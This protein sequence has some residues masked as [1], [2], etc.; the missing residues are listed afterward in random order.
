MR[1]YLAVLKDSFRE[2]L[3]SRVLWI[4]MILTTVVLLAAAPL[5]L[6]EEKSSRLR[7]SSVRN[8]PALVAKIDQELR[9]GGPSPGSQIAVRLSNELKAALDESLK[10][11]PPQISGDILD[12]LIDEL[13][14][15]LPDPT[16]YDPD[17]W[18]NADLGEEA[19]ELL[20]RGVGRLNPEEVARL[21]RLLIRA[22]YPDEV[23]REDGT[24][25]WISYLVFK[26]AGPLSFTKAQM[27]TVIKAVLA[28]IINY[29]VGVFSVFA[30]ILVTSSII[31]QTFEAGAI[32][33]LLSKP[34][35]RTLLFLT[36][37]LG[38]CAF[39]GLN[40][41]YFIVGLWLIVGA[42]FGI[43]SNSLLL[44]I[45][46]ILF[47]FSVY[48]SV[49]ALAGVLWRNA[50]V[51]V[52][53][54]IIFWGGCFGLWA[55][56]TFVDGG[57]IDLHRL[58]K[59]IPADNNLLAVDESQ[60]VFVWRPNDSTWHEVFADENQTPGPM[61]I[62]VR[63]PLTGLTYD[64]HR[65]RLLG[66][67]MPPGGG[68]S[69]FP[70]AP[71]LVEGSRADGWTRKKGPAP[72]AGA[73]ALGV[74]PGGEVVAVARGAVY[75]LRGA[76]PSGG[77]KPPSEP[78][79]A[80]KNEKFV[81]SG[82]DPALRLEPTATVAIDPEAGAIAIFN[83]GVVT[84]LELAESGKYVRKIEK[85]IDAAKDAKSAVLAFSGK[86]ILLGLADGRVLIL[87][88][89]D[90]VLKNESRPEGETAPRFA[91]AAAGGRW[92]S[93]VFHNRRLWLYDSREGRTV[94]SSFTGQGN[95]SA[96]AFAGP[97][98]LLV[99]DRGTRVTRY[100]LDSLRAEER[101]APA[102]SNLEIG[103]YYG[104]LPIYTIFPKPGE[105]GKTVTYLLRDTNDKKQEETLD[106]RPPDLSRPQ[107]SVDVAAPVWSSIAFLSVMLTL[108]CLYV[109]RTDF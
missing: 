66:M 78:K 5:G 39:I 18:R 44:C 48:Y 89:V 65:D 12:A 38:G 67:Q 30:A 22:A 90:L 104:L 106:P 71:T 3:A 37:F 98:R 9:E 87:D 43:W 33:L 57:Y 14:G 29:I 36:K 53:V 6:R 47:L 15:L 97:D 76:K 42:R 93:V 51:S 80:S 27:T 59:L 72:P 26:P 28:F 107:E 79:S 101:H 85:E 55:A 77:G 40:A 21:N 103:Y 102:M 52:V 63:F 46:V 11:S 35:S 81:R 60:G 45:P 74:T 41:A 84:V 8:W 95:I 108:S 70:P 20:A 2:A 100:Q 50:I 105:L 94:A 109:W 58:V 32:D 16:F 23:A 1:P 75:R 83:Q 7:R 73:L 56:K 99:A 92:F 64:A 25:I 17:A 10:E 34:V 61:G 82:P 69:L 96:A 86:T 31:P 54:T 62:V 19:G 49:S 68:M 88:A 13:N 91:A 24:A 4:V